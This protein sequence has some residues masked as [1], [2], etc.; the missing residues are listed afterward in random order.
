MIPLPV[1]HALKNPSSAS[2][3]PQVIDV[4]EISL[5]KCKGMGS[6]PRRENFN[7]QAIVANKILQRSEEY[8]E[9][10]WKEEMR[11]RAPQV[12]ETLDKSYQDVKVL[13][14]TAEKPW[15]SPVLNFWALAMHKER[16]DA[17]DII[18]EQMKVWRMKA[19]E[20]CPGLEDIP[21]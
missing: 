12:K 16:P 5:G 10:L 21:A 7:A 1:P 17:H 11:E 20:I 3:K 4:A 9:A 13:H 14:Y 6:Q 8:K 19:K 15:T 18:A 2:E